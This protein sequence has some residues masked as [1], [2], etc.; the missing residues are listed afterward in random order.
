MKFDMK[1]WKTLAIATTA[2]VALPLG[3]CSGLMGNSDNTQ[4]YNTAEAQPA[5]PAPAHAFANENANANTSVTFDG[6]RMSHRRVRA[7][8]QALNAKGASLRVDGI[9]GPNTRS[10][11]R[12]FQQQKGLQA[13]GAIDQPT[14]RALDLASYGNRN[15][16]AG[17]R[18]QANAANT[19]NTSNNTNAGANMSGSNNANA[20][21]NQNV[22]A[23]NR[24]YG[25]Q[26]ANS[27]NAPN[28]QGNE[29]VRELQEALNANGASLQVDGK[30][31]SNT[32]NALRNY[33]QSHGL[34][35]TGSLDQ[36]TRQ[37]LNIVNK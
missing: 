35:A 34:P 21:D 29:E 31:G 32:R 37:N 17:N 25:V 13:S 6:Q 23:A 4:R 12:N 8:Q 15:N 36:K 10:A 20:A 30:M 3:A 18:Q 16:G 2:I 22:G 33:Q 27:G 28:G 7:L 5:A 26:G 1:G 9:M 11:L 24:Q 19:M 14:E